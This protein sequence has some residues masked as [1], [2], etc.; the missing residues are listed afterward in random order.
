M[1]DLCRKDTQVEV[2]LAPHMCGRTFYSMCLDMRPASLFGLGS[3]AR[4]A[5]SI[6]HPDCMASLICSRGR[7][8]GCASC[9]V[10]RQGRNQR[11]SKKHLSRR[12]ADKDD[13]GLLGGG[14]D[15]LIEDV[16]HD[17]D[18]VDS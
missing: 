15:E 4:S 12:E 3:T 9:G 11:F 2:S 13:E 18:R 14:D 7:H 16:V 6:A 10:T 17:D 8:E 1:L 5:H